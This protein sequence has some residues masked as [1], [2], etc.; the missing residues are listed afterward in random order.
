MYYPSQLLREDVT[1]L[2]PISSESVAAD[3]RKCGADTGPVYGEYTCVP[4]WLNWLRRKRSGPVGCVPSPSPRP[5]P[6]PNTLA[7]WVN[8]DF[9]VSSVPFQNR[10]FHKSE[11]RCPAGT[12]IVLAFFITFTLYEDWAHCCGLA[13]EHAASQRTEET[14]LV[15]ISNVAATLGNL[16]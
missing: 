8:I 3:K 7:L 6:L 5:P 16:Y 2:R 15:S 12:M 11:P 1:H 10:C 13:F 14:D 4:A 9:T